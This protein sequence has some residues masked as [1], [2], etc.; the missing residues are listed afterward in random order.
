MDGLS[1]MLS[2]RSQRKTNTIWFH[3]YVKYE[4]TNKWT[5][6]TETRH[7]NTENHGC[8]IWGGGVGSMGK[9][10]KGD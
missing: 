2:E 3:L 8:Q 5:N 4:K 1:I 7:I 9:T 10:G 6:R